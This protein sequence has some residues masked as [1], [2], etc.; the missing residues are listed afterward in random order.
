MHGGREARRAIAVLV[1]FVAASTGLVAAAAAPA[2]PASDGNL[3]GGAPAASPELPAILSAPWAE[4]AGWDPA[5]LEEVSDPA[6]L[7][8][9]VDLVVSLAPRSAALYAAPHPGSRL[10]EAAIA[11]AFAPD[12]AARGALVA[13]LEAHGLS[14]DRVA[15]DGLSLRV[16]GP[17]AA[18]GAAFGTTLFAGSW[19][20]RSV[21]FPSSPPSLPPSLEAGV[22]S[23]VGLS[24]GFTQFAFSLAPAPL[25]PLSGPAQGRTA[26]LITPSAAHLLYGLSDLY[27]FTGNGSTFAQGI[28]IAVVLWGDGYDPADLETFFQEQYSSTFPAV[29]ITY[30]A[31]DG[32]PVPSASAVSDP[33]LAPQELTLD[34]EWAGSAAP[35]ADLHA[36]YAPDGPASNAYSPTDAHLED[37]LQAAIDISG[38]DVVSMSFGTPDGADLPLQSS[39]AQSFAA[40]TQ[41]GITVLAASG[42][43]GGTTKAGC[44]G[45]FSPEFPAASPDVLAVGGTEPVESLDPFGAVTGLDSEGAWNGSGGGF[46]QVYST[47]AWQEVGS[48]Q[49]PT[50]AN[51]HLGIPD[52]AGPAFDNYFYYDGGDRAGRG[53]SFATPMWAGLVAEMD[54]LHGGP[55][56]FLDQRLYALGAEEAA[57]EAPQGLVD[58][59]SGS[60]C[61]A[62]AGAGWDTVT[63]WGSPRGMTLYA[64]LSSSFVSI[65]LSASAATAAPGGSITADV[66]VTNA[67]THAAIPGLAVGFTLVAQDY[68]GPCGGTLASATGTTDGEGNASAA[69]G[70]PGCFLGGSALLT[71]VVASGGYFGTASTTVAINLV[72]VNGFLSIIQ[73]FPYNVIAFVLIVAAAVGIGYWIG[74]RRRPRRRRRTAAPRGPETV[75][76]GSDAASGPGGPP[77]PPPSAGATSAY[78]GGPPSMAFAAPPGF[79][80]GEALPAAAPP[81]GPPGGAGPTASPPPRTCAW[82]GSVAAPGAGVCGIC[83]NPLA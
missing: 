82:C 68:T 29:T 44:T 12:V 71:V 49:G 14:V 75:P 62:T 46:S 77:P 32:A 67:T 63:G 28:G 15:P 9:S 80:G 40:A 65:A 57:G 79:P 53:T 81:P 35:G 60:N 73:V 69:L 50:E 26:T 45:S 22:S 78:G 23:V 17:A 38:V 19:G 61:I 31:V 41:A 4:R 8:G 33:S 10:S 66:A 42:D 48:A 34:L 59:T 1:A 58:V 36:V 25:S 21:H 18:A 51:G 7:A 43:N 16:S 56:G 11:G 27:N 2:P 6:P 3:A 52:V 47:P 24:D 5:Y 76:A 72:G 39:F 74:E 13:Y 54:A 83:G 55:L 30:H 37:A 20:G 64:G 70:I